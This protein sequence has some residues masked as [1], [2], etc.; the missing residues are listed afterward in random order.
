MNQVHSL[1]AVTVIIFLFA[2]FMRL[3]KDMPKALSLVDAASYDIYMW[4]M[5]FVF[6]ANFIIEKLHITANLPSFAIRF[7]CAYGLT[8]PLCIVWGKIKKKYLRGKKA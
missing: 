7:V 4:H 8:I 1:Y 2:L 3:P 6:F 5:L